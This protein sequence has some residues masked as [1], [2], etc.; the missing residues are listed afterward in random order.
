MKTHFQ[1]LFKNL[2]IFIAS[3]WLFYSCVSVYTPNNT[4]TNTNTNTN[5][6]TNVVKVVSNF[7]ENFDQVSKNKYE[8]ATI[9]TNSGDWYFEN[10]MMG[11]TDNDVKNGAKAIRIK[12][13]GL[14]RFD[15]DL[16]SGIYQIKLK[17][18]LYQSDKTAAFEVRIS[19]N[20][21]NT[22]NKI[23]NTITLLINS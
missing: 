5:K 11:S 18:G 2:T 6:T 16:T 12:E 7:P 14:V 22:W 13:D 21:G 10:A 20:R 9:T 3:S 15:T 8:T 1:S 17:A 19:T 23:G 4:N